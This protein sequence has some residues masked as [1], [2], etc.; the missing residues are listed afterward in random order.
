MIYVKSTWIEMCPWSRHHCCHLLQQGKYKNS[1]A[2]LSSLSKDE[3]CCIS[4][5]AVKLRWWLRMSFVSINFSANKRMIISTSSFLTLVKHYL[6]GGNA[7][8]LMFVHGRVNWVRASVGMDSLSGFQQLLMFVGNC[9][10][11]HA[12][13][14]TDAHEWWWRGSLFFLILSAW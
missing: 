6:N 5:N 1:V 7:C 14:T 10:C 3:C 2:T 9:V 13:E 11:P 8:L 4:W 12:E